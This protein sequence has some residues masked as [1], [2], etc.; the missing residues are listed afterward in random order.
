M[1]HGLISPRCQKPYFPEKEFGMFYTCKN[2]VWVEM[3]P[4]NRIVTTSFDPCKRKYIFSY[5]TSDWYVNDYFFP[6]SIRSFTWNLDLPDGVLSKGSISYLDVLSICYCISLEGH[7]C[8]NYEG[9]NH[10][11]YGTGF[12]PS[13]WWPAALPSLLP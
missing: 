1:S 5:C 12:T 13:E 7:C 6:S 3:F 11:K 10:F 2:D 8:G 9:F 4:P